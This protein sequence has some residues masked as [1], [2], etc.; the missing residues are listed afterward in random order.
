MQFTVYS[1]SV[2]FDRVGRVWIGN[3][4]KRGV[5]RKISRDG[6]R[7]ELSIAGTCEVNRRAKRALRLR[8]IIQCDDYLGE[9]IATRVKPT[10]VLSYESNSRNRYYMFL[11]VIAPP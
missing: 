6:Y 10:R 1:A 3:D 9:H 11:V 8:Q 5:G 4:G 2:L 7:C